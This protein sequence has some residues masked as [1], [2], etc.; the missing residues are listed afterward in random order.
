MALFGR[1][2][3][4]ADTS[5]LEKMAGAICHRGPD[6]A[7]FWSQKSAGLA[8]QEV[9]EESTGNLQPPGCPAHLAVSFDGRL[10]NRDDLLSTCGTHL[11]NAEEP[12]DSALVVSAYQQ[13]GEG[14]AHYLNGD[15]AVALFD[16]SQQ[17]LLLSRDVMGIR[18]LYYWQSQQIFLAASEV[19]A[20]L[21]H[22][23]V[24]TAPDDDGLA[25]FLLS[26]DAFEV[27][28]TCFRDIYRVPPGRTVIVERARVRLFQHWDFDTSRQICYSS[29][30]DYAEELRVLFEQAVKRRL[31]SACP[32]GVLVSGGLDSSAV[33]CQ[34]ELLRQAGKVTAA[35]LVGMAMVFPEGTEADECRYLKDIEA[36]YNVQIGKRLFS[37]FQLEDAC[38]WQTEFPRLEWDSTTALLDTF[39]DIGCRTVLDGVYGDQFM[40]SDAHLITLAR[41]LHW[42]KFKREF[43]A[44]ASTMKEVEPRDLLK[45]YGNIVLRTWIPECMKPWLRSIRYK[46]SSNLFPDWYTRPFQR[47]AFERSAWIRRPALQSEQ[48]RECYETVLWASRLNAVEQANKLSA[49][50]GLNSAHPFLDRDLVQ[51]MMAIP[52]EIV[53][54]QG[55]AKGLFRE[56]MRGVL[57]E[58]IRVRDWKADFT[59][60][61]SEAT[62]RAYSRFEEYLQPNCLAVKY[63]YLDGN[64]L[65]SRF[66]QHRAK[67][68]GRTAIPAWRATDTAGLEIWLRLFFGKSLDRGAPQ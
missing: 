25:D 60:L 67:L 37:T 44:Q 35:P 65:V 58:S 8:N 54:W 9:T 46:L 52:G 1:N 2:D 64:V 51:F 26:G 49:A 31:R 16:S 29:I 22:P 63:G 43:Q 11:R 24:N 13:W 45:Y 27:H 6:G 39:R 7:T 68:E 18:P 20:L 53:S 14:F 66:A 15:F 38:I 62:L 47:R 30:S 61:N 59:R 40:F 10:D 4:P 42:R 19:K 21:A 23:D 41:G 57:P 17:M 34:G 33:F 32:V 56:A 28:R 55:A 12:S 3:R 48:V 50:R 36:A 5:L